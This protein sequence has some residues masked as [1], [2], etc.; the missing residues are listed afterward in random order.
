MVSFMVSTGREEGSIFLLVSSVF[1]GLK[2]TNSFR[3]TEITP[4]YNVLNFIN[5]RAIKLQIY[6]LKNN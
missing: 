2:L 5:L 6:M 3:V 1:M 4:S